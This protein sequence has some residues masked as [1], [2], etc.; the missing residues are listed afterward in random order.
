MISIG[1]DVVKIGT[2]V[3]FIG[4]FVVFTNGVV[5]ILV[6][7]D[8]IV[9]VV[10]NVDDTIAELHKLQIIFEIEIKGISDV[11]VDECGSDCGF[12]VDV[13][14]ILDFVPVLS[15]GLVV[16]EV[17]CVIILIVF[18]VNIVGRKEVK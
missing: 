3:T 1:L 16:V 18:V 12:V 8:V 13:Y 2:V 17:S 14:K 7:I 15:V 5:N 11:S 9:F 4:V 10:L 6:L